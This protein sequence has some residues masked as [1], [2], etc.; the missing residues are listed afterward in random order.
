MFSILRCLSWVALV[1]SAASFAS[2]SAQADEPLAQQVRSL[3]S[4]RC[5]ACHG[6]DEEER[7][8]GLRLDERSAMLGEADSGMRPVVPGDP[9]ASELLR[10]IVS[11]DESERMPPLDF[12]P[13]LPPAEIDLIRQWIEQG[14]KLPQHWSF[15]VPQRSALPQPPQ[16][17]DFPQWQT[18]PVDRFVRARQVEHGLQPS[19]EASRAELLRRLSLDL[20]GLPPTPAE[21]AHFTADTRPD[22]YERQ[23]DRLLASPAFGE[24]WA[25]KWLDLAR[26]ADSAG[27][28]DDPSRTIWAYRDWV[29]NALNDNLSVAQF[30]VD[31]IAGD[32]LPQPTTQQLVATAFHRNTL[33]NNE[34]GTNDEEFRNVAVVD[35]VNTTM[36]VWMGVTMACAQCHTHKYDPFTHEEYFQLFAIFNQTQDEDRRDES[37][38]LELYTDAQAREREQW[39]TRLQVIEKLLQQ[40]TPEIRESMRRWEQRLS[41]PS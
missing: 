20:I 6:P 12:G 21:V 36:A 2:P 9:E 1:C 35:R 32:L 16:A 22:A 38:T 31:Q 8:A 33:T 39:Q 7:Q 27:Y 24:H 17:R 4:N 15:V 14:A 34:G 26:Y 18:H 40:P 10:R 28:A 11:G 13:P 30:T 5:F 41:E 37:P 29:I 25:R 3:L 23:V 19:G